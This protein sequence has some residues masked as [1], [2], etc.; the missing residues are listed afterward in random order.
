MRLELVSRTRTARSTL[1]AISTLAVL[2]AE[3]EDVG[4]CFETTA[5]L[6]DTHQVWIEQIEAG[7]LTN[8]PLKFKAGIG[9]RCGLVVEA[10]EVVP[11]VLDSPLAALAAV[12]LR[13]SFADGRIEMVDPLAAPRWAYR[14]SLP[15]T[16]YGPADIQDLAAGLNMLLNPAHQSA[17]VSDAPV[18][19]NILEKLEVSA[20][21]LMS[22]E[23]TR[24]HEIR[25]DFS[26]VNENGQEE[27]FPLWLWSSGSGVWNQIAGGSVQEYN[28]GDRLLLL[29]P[30][31]L[32]GGTPSLSAADENHF[33]NFTNHISLA[34]N[35]LT[36]SK[37]QKALEEVKA[38]VSA[39]QSVGEAE[40]LQF[41]AHHGNLPGAPWGEEEKT[42]GN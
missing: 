31:T 35:T 10:L 15:R 24:G 39:I 20:L 19:P 4:P 21:P 40:T 13:L 37:A 29:L 34:N 23:S 8:T 11:P 5:E 18:L 14:S 12:R 7:L 16:E 26:F 33:D 17:I 25:H 27:F 3:Q 38:L 9:R 36:F 1:A 2:A 42:N 6:S 30:G 28:T 41:V 22:I 32:E